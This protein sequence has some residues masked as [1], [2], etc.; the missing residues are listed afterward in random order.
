MH[1]VAEPPWIHQTAHGISVLHTVNTR[2]PVLAS[3]VV[4]TN[5]SSSRKTAAEEFI[6]LQCVVEGSSTWGG[7][8]RKTQWL[9]VQCSHQVSSFLVPHEYHPHSTGSQGCT[10]RGGM[11][12][13]CHDSR[14][15]NP[16]RSD[17]AL[18]GMAHMILL[19]GAVQWVEPSRWL[20]RWKQSKLHI[21]SHWVLTLGGNCTSFSQNTNTNPF[22][23]P[24]PGS[25]SCWYTG[26]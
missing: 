25:P 1:P 23:S 2:A 20:R 13:T 14:A 8:L 4:T 16:K 11:E 7:E 26:W 6:L 10:C 9:P 18:C 24:A 17:C 15:L 19:E 3:Q 21:V 22:P 12:K 5:R